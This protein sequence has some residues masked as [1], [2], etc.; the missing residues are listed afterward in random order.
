PNV[1]QESTFWSSSLNNLIDYD[2][3]SKLKYAGDFYLWL[4]FS[5]ACDLKIVKSYIGGFKFHGEQ[6]SST[7]VGNLN[8]Y[9]VEM[10]SMV[11]KPKVHQLALA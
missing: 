7:M 9:Q 4:Q 1:Q 6:L 5:K 2:Y 10:R 8:A 3:L 11:A